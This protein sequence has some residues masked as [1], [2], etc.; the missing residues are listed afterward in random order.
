[1]LVLNLFDSNFSGQACSVAKQAPRSFKYVERL[2]QFDGISLF[3]DRWMY[4]PVVDEIQ[5]KWKIGWLHE[6]RELHPEN[7]ENIEQVM[8]KFD[9]ILTTETELWAHES[10]KFLPCVRGGTWVDEKF[11]GIYPKT[12]NVSII[13][14]SKDQLQGHKLRHEAAKL[15]G[16]DVYG[17]GGEHI[18][19][20]KDMAYRHHRFAIVIEASKRENWFSEHLLDCVA[21]GTIPIYWGCTNIGHW[22]NRRGIIEFGGLHDLPNI[23][24]ALD[25]GVY[26]HMLGAA[27]DNLM[28]L[29]EYRVS[30]EWF[31]KNSLKQ[32]LGLS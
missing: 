4:N 31:L 2:M 26:R 5:S 7:Y 1:M 9:Y 22:L 24:K 11:W 14:S 32:R 23:V 25:D 21:F 16:V 29:P 18:G 3:T 30:E 19:T 20:D 12:R 13:V 10:G 8:D 17:Y 27:Y 6:G 28:L 15:P